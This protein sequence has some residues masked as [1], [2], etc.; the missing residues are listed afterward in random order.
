MIAEATCGVSANS[1]NID[2]CVAAM[3]G[4]LADE[5]KLNN[6]GQAGRRYAL[7]HFSKEVC[8]SQIENMLSQH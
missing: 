4:L 5:S 2:A 1:A 6:I 8:V 7:D 3:R